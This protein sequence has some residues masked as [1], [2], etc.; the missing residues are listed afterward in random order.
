[1]PHTQT[2]QPDRVLTPDADFRITYHGTLTTITPLSNA[3]REWIEENV[4][5]ELWQWFGNSIGVEPRYVEHLAETM[6]EES[7]VMEGDDLCEE[8]D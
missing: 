1:M 3:C 6:I 7:F 2:H 5:I 4:E 8:E